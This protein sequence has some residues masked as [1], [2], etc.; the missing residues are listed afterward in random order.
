MTSRVVRR[1]VFVGSILTIL[2]LPSVG[3]AQEATVSGTV[4]DSTAGVLP[5]ATIKAVNEASGNSFEAVTDARFVL[6][7]AIPHPHDLHLG[8][9]SVHTSPAA[10]R[11]GER[12]LGEI[13]RRLR[14]EGRL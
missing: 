14:N 4:A 1:L 5:G 11:E 13:Q 3:H 7:T 9:Y 6:G 8:Q 10:L 2:A 12:W